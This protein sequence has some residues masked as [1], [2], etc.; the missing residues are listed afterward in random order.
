MKIEHFEEGS[1]KG[2][3]IVIERKDGQKIEIKIIQEAWEKYLLL[4]LLGLIVIIGLHKL[5]FKG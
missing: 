1:E 3:L 2:F 5:I 4:G